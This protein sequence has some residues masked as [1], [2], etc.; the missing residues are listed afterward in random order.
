[1]NQTRISKLSPLVHRYKDTM[2]K[3]SWLW[4]C[5][6]RSR[7]LDRKERARTVRQSEEGGT[8]APYPLWTAVRA[9]TP[10]SVGAALLG[11]L[12]T[13]VAL[14]SSSWGTACLLLLYTHLGLAQTLFVWCCRVVES[15]RG[16]TELTDHLLLFCVLWVYFQMLSI[17]EQ[18]SGTISKPNQLAKDIHF[19]S[20]AITRRSATPQGL[21]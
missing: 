9:R 19:K 10:M 6:S 17:W 2:Q 1:M 8:S 15:Y 11:M 16:W 5:L 21:E 18:P 20:T 13:A 4:N 7:K 14:Y 3:C 12:E